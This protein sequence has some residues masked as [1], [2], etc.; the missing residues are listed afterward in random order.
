L[1]KDNKSLL[2]LSTCQGMMMTANSLLGATSALVGF[3]L[4]TDKSLSTVPLALVFLAAMLT[5]IPASLL[6]K[7]IGRRNGFLLGVMAGLLGATISAWAITQS[8]FIL[9]CCGISLIGIANGFGGYYRFAAA[10]GVNASRRSTAISLVLAG[11]VIAAFVGPNLAN[12]TRDMISSFAFAG[13]YMSLVLVY[14]ISMLFLIFLDIKLPKERNIV[15]PARPL[16]QIILQPA[17]LVA[18]FGAMS[19]FGVMSIIMTAT[20][21]AMHAGHHQF[22]ETAFV[23]QWHIFAMYAPSFFTGRL[24][25]RF[26]VLNIMLTGAILMIACVS[27]NTSGNTLVH[28]WTGLFLLGIGW[29]LLFIGGTTLLTETYTQSE[30][31]KAQAFNDFLIFSNVSFAALSAGALLHHFGWHFVNYSVLPVLAVVVMAIIWLKFT[32]SR[33]IVYN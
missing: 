11:G 12:W 21:L 27:I 33:G 3:A 17:Y 4:A 30:M 24:I 2:I 26:G 25:N 20:P 31:A 9:Y 10:D 6:M 18:V 16:K 8:N 28:Y 13:S 19:G 23:I 1:E 15:E 32:R 14:V 22:S 5:T 7:K 29:N